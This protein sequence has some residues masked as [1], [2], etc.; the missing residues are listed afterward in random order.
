MMRSWS[1][2]NYS[3]TVGVEGLRKTTNNLRQFCRSPGR[4]LDVSN[5]STKQDCLVSVTMHDIRR[6]NDKSCYHHFP[7]TN[8]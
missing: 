7:K 2:L 1:N 6:N 3:A 5:P 4:N 8:K